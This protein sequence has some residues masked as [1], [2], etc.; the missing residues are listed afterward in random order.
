MPLDSSN[1][2]G[3]GS[4]QG[5]V[6]LPT[7]KVDKFCEV[8]STMDVVHTKLVE[9]IIEDAVEQPYFKQAIDEFNHL[10]GEQ[11]SE[12]Y[13]NWYGKKSPIHHKLT[14][15][16]GFRSNRR[17][18]VWIYCML[19]NLSF[20]AFISQLVLDYVNAYE[21]KEEELIPYKIDPPNNVNGWEFDDAGEVIQTEVH[22][23]PNDSPLPSG[24][25]HAIIGRI[26]HK[27]NASGGKMVVFEFAI[28]SRIVRAFLSYRN[29][30]NESA[31]RIARDKLND[32]MNAVGLVKG[33][34]LKA[35]IGKELEIYVGPSN[36]EEYP[37][38]NDIFQYRALPTNGEPS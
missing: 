36:S 32:I 3:E 19:K 7:A 14:N 16:C 33:N 29:P 34:V 2:L 25:Y 11:I 12:L 1:K 30:K 27:D 37:L 38:C 8:C 35:L 9:A 23:R 6:F 4:F 13:R 17:L 24:W 31:Q 20:R 5:R 22:A 10:N 21:A 28:E 26:E 18:S 15:V